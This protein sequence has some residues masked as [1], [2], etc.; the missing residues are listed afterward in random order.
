M[1]YAEFQVEGYTMRMKYEEVTCKFC[2][3]PSIV[4]NGTRNGVQYWLCKNCGRGFVDNKGLPKMRYSIDDVASAIYQYYAGSSLNEIRGYV[5]QHSGFR[6]SD[7]TIYSW[8]TR[9]T[10]IAI[11]KAREYTPKVGDVWASDETVL[12]IGGKKI[13]RLKKGMWF[14]DVIDTKTRFLLA[15]HIS[16]SRTTE[17]A[18]T[19]MEKAWERADKV[20]KVV[21]T[22]K[23]QAYLDGVSTAFGRTTTKHIQSR[24]FTVEV[25]TNLIERFQGTL[26]DRTEVMRGMKTVKTARLILDGWLIYYNFFRPHESLKDKTPA[27]VAGIKFPFKN[28]LDVVKSQSP[29]A[30][31]ARKPIIVSSEYGILFPSP[32]SYR[33]RLPYKPK[34]NKLH[35]RSVTPTI[36]TVKTGCV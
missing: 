28:W 7:S 27:E 30:Q 20:P 8:V 4:K 22:D 1:K 6:P 34:A 33:K 16:Q 32:K 18:T 10:M 9:F 19:L 25:N 11:D 3:S 29:L 23:L 36:S 17:D 35:K 21:I 14:W 24:G 5:D 15:S 12:H 13:D 2:G 31:E 26:K